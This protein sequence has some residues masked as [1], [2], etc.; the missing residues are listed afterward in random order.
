M[1]V[2]FWQCIS[3]GHHSK[4]E[5]T[6]GDYCKYRRGEGYAFVTQKPWATFVEKN[7]SLWLHADTLRL[8]FDSIGQADKFT[9]YNHC[10]FFLKRYSRQMRLAYL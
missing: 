3:E 9:A 5:R 7:D 1:P 2:M 4:A 6:R 10:K 8:Y